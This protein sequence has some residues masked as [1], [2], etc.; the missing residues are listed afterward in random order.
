MRAVVQRTGWSEVT[1]DDE[2]IGRASAGLTVLLGVG[3]GDTEADARYMAEKIAT[4]R[5]FQDEAGKMNRSVLDVAGQVLAI[6][7]FTLYGDCRKG[8]RPGFDAAA[9]AEMAKSLYEKFVQ[10]LQLRGI[11]VGC[12][13]FQAEMK[14]V[15]ENQGPVTMLI[16]SKKSF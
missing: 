14:V 16:D 7:Q 5:I 13:R 6:S 8:R 10:E 12:G 2:V 3:C 11:E 9:P 1:V 4:L 15:L